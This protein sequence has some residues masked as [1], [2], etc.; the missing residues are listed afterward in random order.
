MLL[1]KTKLAL[2]PLHGLGLFAAEPIPKG[3]KVWLFTKGFDLRY[4]PQEVHWLP[5]LLKQTVMDYGYVWMV[6]GEVIY[7]SDNARFMNH[8]DAPNTAASHP[9]AEDS[10]AL[11]DIDEGEEL[12]YSYYDEDGDWRR[13]LGHL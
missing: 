5:P 8:V 10:I 6:T 3:K 1:V 11:R 13:K 9:E 4:T 12:T 2:S 7:C